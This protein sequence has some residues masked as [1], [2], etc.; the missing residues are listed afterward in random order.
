[1]RE[2]EYTPNRKSTYRKYRQSEK[3]RASRVANQKAYA[4]R[5]PEKIKAQVAV[6]KAKRTGDITEQPCEICGNLNVE[7]H[8]DDYNE[9][10]NVRW[11][12]K[13]HHDEYHRRN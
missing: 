4:D 8:H 6:S 13:K 2:L 3:G 9:P 11:L 12:C 1:M 5:W 7:A 10:L